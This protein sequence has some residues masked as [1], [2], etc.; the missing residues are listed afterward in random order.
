M[1]YKS[2]V[3]RIKDEEGQAIVLVAVA[4]SL[5]LF[6]A[7]GLAVDGS[8]LYSQRQMA[9]AAADAAAQAGMMSIFDGT[10]ALAG[11]AAAFTAGT[12]FNCTT[13]D[14]ETPCVYARKN[15]FG[16]S[17]DDI[18]AVTFPTSAPGVK[19]SSDTTNLIKVTVSRNVSTTLMRFLGPTATWVK[20]SATA[21]IVNV[22]NP[23]PI[24]VTHP[25]LANALYLNGNTDSIKICGGPTRSIQVNSLDPAAFLPSQGTVDLSQAGPAD[26]GNCT[27]TQGGADF[28]V[29]GGPTANPNPGTAVNL[30]TA[31]T[32]HYLSHASPIQDPLAGVSPPTKP[33]TT[34]PA[35][36]TIHSPTDGCTFA[37]CTEYSPGLYSTPA[38]LDLTGV[39]NVIF[40]PGLYYIQSKGGFTMKNSNGGAANNSVMCVGCAADTNTGTGMLVYDTG[41]SGSTT[42]NNPTGGFTIDTKAFGAF[43]GPTNTTTQPVG[44]NGCTTTGGCVVPAAPYFGVL[45]WEDRTADAH[46]PPNGQHILGAGNGCFS[47]IGT[48]YMTNTQDIMTSSNGA[49]YQAVEY[50]GGPCSTTSNQGDIIAGTLT[51]KGGAAIRMFLLPYG[52]LT[53]RQVAMVN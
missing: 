45:F 36:A 9:Q 15:G 38:G 43:Q 14:A 47:V 41:P 11:N 37:N 13:S 28:G 25:Y 30:G 24:L 18:V 52:F 16:G 51:L 5:F 33:S 6:A 7:I 34:A 26:S 49:Q 19:L 17:S 53:I 35:P 27:T 2:F 44:T 23:T 48:I 4:M 42:G 3:T 22:V 31:G 40:K 29:F 10:N 8:N 39:A 50:H 12:A 20:A 46:K 1:R 21:A 32:G